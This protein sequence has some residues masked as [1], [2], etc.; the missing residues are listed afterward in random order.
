[1]DED[2]EG[3]LVDKA[4]QQEME[5][6]TLDIEAKVENFDQVS[7]FINENLEAH[8]CP[9]KAMMQIEVVVEEIFTNIAKYAYGDN[10]GR[11]KIKIDIQDQKEVEITFMDTGVP[12][13]PLANA[14]PDVTLSAEER[15]IGGLG[16]FMS[17]QMMDHM[18]YEYSDGMNILRIKKNL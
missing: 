14:D 5:L 10:V 12:Y 7:Q 9:L 15:E 16:I 2:K 11:A 17:K 6:N 3:D 1:M 8:D 13:N 18:A 4:S